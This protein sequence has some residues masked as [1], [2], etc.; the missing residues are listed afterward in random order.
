MQS[1]AND[2]SVIK[3]LKGILAQEAC[4]DTI[5]LDSFHLRLPGY[6]HS[7]SLPPP[8]PYFTHVQEATGLLQEIA[9]HCLPSDRWCQRQTFTETLSRLSES[10]WLLKISAVKGKGQ[11]CLWCKNKIKPAAAPHCHDPNLLV[12]E[13]KTG[14]YVSFFGISLLPLNL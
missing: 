4:K 1:N 7:R 2:G 9:W 12:V 10:V 11:M 8:P 5:N 14:C 6:N 3:E 13:I